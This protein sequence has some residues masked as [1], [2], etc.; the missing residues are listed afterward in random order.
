M[1]LSQLIKDIF[2]TDTRLPA[3]V[4]QAAFIQ[5]L[6][7]KDQ[8][9]RDDAQRLIHWYSRDRLEILEYL[10]LQ[11][12]KTFNKTTEW[13]YPIINGVRRTVRR[14]STAYQQPPL[15][16]LVRGDKVINPKSKEREKV[17]LMLSQINVN[18]KMRSLDRWSTL[19]NTVHVEVV[20]RKGFIDWDIRL[21][22]QVTV[23]QDP[24]DFLEFV[25][26]AYQW[27]PIDPETLEPT[28]GW[29]YWSEEQHVFI[30]A[31]GI[32]MG[33]SR[34]DGK[35][36]YRGLDG[37]PVIPI[38]T[39]RKDE[40][41]ADYWGRFGADLVDAFQVMNVQ[42]GN[43]WETT[44]MQTAGWPV[45]TNFDLEGG[46]DVLIGPKNPL[47]ATKVTKDDV[48]PSV[49]FPKPDPDIKE[50]QAFLDWF[51]KAN[52]ASYGLPPSAWALDEGGRGLA[53]SGLSKFMDN[54]ELLELRQE[55]ATQWEAV[56]QDLFAK[57]VIVWNQ[58]AAD[59][60]KVPDDLEL[61]LTFPETKIPESPKEKVERWALAIAGG[62]ASAVDYF[63]DE[64]GLDEADALEKA[65]RIAKQNKEIRDAG[66]T[67][68]QALPP[69]PGEGSGGDNA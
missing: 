13:Q 29:V 32:S 62:V 36:P 26:F 37:V 14:L 5:T 4:V 9:E 63:M 51:I 50:T 69:E 38:T 49:E 22:P 15:R 40:D 45:I 55:N 43:I 28:K 16:E 44:S 48:P 30:S 61:R 11:A 67:P 25:K 59:G 57:S 19:L 46:K 18:R 53:T 23:I 64:E 33:M 35:N 24:G 41:I 68:V 27:D 7:K 39:V 8:V 1:A 60:D 42:L 58:W 66:M 52:A 10:Q 56:E 34:P 17:D 3:A 31:G 47:V 2:G 12:Q 21:R 6:E 65:L 20:P 54:I